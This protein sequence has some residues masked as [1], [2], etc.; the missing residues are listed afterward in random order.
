LTI[1]WPPNRA[2]TR[3]S[4]NGEENPFRKSSRSVRLVKAA[5]LRRL[6]SAMRASSS[7]LALP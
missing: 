7:G 5:A 4:L 1:R 2:L 3:K 6:S